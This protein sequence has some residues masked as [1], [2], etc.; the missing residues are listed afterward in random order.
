M[1]ELVEIATFLEL[2]K[3]KERKITYTFHAISEA[4]YRKLISENETEIKVFE[5][6]INEGTIYLIVEQASE[7]PDEKKFKL[8]CHYP[9]G[10]FIIYIIAINAEIRLITVY[11]TSK[12][13]QKKLYKY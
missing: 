2:L 13:L 3:Q 6:D 10:G 8:Y 7:I 12:S 4:K 5:S 11:R 1:E 9:K